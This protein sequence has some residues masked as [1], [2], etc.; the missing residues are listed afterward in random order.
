VPGTLSDLRSIREAASKTFMTISVPFIKHSSKESAVKKALEIME[1]GADSVHCGSWN[2]NFMKY[3]SE[4]KIPFQGHAGLVPRRSTWIGGVRAFGKTQKE[5]IQLYQDIKDIEN[6]GAWGVEVECVP[7]KIA[8]EITKKTSLFTLSIGAGSKCDGQFLFSEDILGCSNIDFPRHAKKYRDFN[9]LYA[10]IQKD[11][12]AAY[13]E[14][15]K[16]VV[17]QKFPSGKHSV[18]VDQNELLL[19]KKFLNK[20]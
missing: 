7:E 3:L 13:T 20:N 6:T 16:D 19:F 18:S 8:E 5:A 14:F 11:R 1:I 2:L 9:K 12:I 17:T 10:K 15:K 4:F